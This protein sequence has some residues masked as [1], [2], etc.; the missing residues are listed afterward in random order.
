MVRVGTRI[1][2]SASVIIRTKNE[3]RL[4]GE[5]L[6]RVFRQHARPIEV[7]VIDSG[8]T[9]RT[10]EIARASDARVMTISPEEWGYA[11]ALN[12]AAAQARGD[13]LVMLS[14]HCLPVDDDWLGNL[15]RH[16]DDPTVAAAWGSQFAPNRARPQPGPPEWQQPGT[17]TR[18]NWTWGLSNANG[19]V[20]AE[21]WEGVPFD[22]SFPAA[23]D[24]QWARVMLNRGYCVVH[25][26]AAA[27]WHDRHPIASSYVRQR[28]VMEGFAMMFPEGGSERPRLTKAAVRAGWLT[29]LRHLQTRDLDLLASDLRRVPSSSAA[30][31]GGLL[32]RRPSRAS[33]RLRRAPR[34]ASDLPAHERA[35][36]SLR[37]P[38]V[39]S[40]T[41]PAEEIGEH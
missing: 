29:V 5:T 7:I 32:A 2:L 39:S 18:E 17:Y 36:G 37:E 10:L 11:R 38:A 30:I 3:E 4:L 41:P 19:A 20:R 34:P 31:I 26:P 15:V 12:V 28:L 13:V 24:K 16:F 25:D 21:L 8:S 22:E 35:P 23:E 1:M 27:V 40:P 14:A 33:A 9:D 6:V